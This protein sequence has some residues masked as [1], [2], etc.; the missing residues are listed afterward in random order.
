[1][2][3]PSWVTSGGS[4]GNYVDGIAMSYT[5]VATPS[6]PSNGVYY[7][8]FSGNLPV[9]LGLDA[10]SGTIA[11]TPA[12][13]SEDTQT[14]FVVR[15]TEF[16][17]STIIGTS[18]R[19]FSMSIINNP[20]SWV[21]PI[22]NIG[23]FNQ[24]E[25]LTYTFAA[26]P[27]GTGNTI[28]YSLINGSFPASVGSA[29]TLDTN[30]GELTGT[31]A[32]VS[33]STTSTFTLRATEY[34]GS[35]LV[36][37]S[38][39]I[40]T[41]TI[42]IPQP[43]W[44]TPAG[45]IG[46]FAEGTSVNY[47][48]SG[49]PGSVGDTVRYTLLNGSLPVTQNINSPMI[50]SSNGLLSGIPGEVSANT[51]SDFTIRLEEYSGASRISTNDRTFSMTVI[52][53]DAPTFITTGPW[54]YSDSVWVSIS[55][56]YNNPDPN[57]TISITLVSGQLPPGI[58]LGSQGLLQGYPDIPTSSSITYNFTLRISNGTL[59]SDQ[60][61]SFT[62]NLETGDRN[63]TIYN[64]QPP[65]L[66]MS[67]DQYAA[68]YFTAPS[69]GV[70][71]QGT[72]FIFKIIGHDF[73]NQN[74]TYDIG[75]LDDLGNTAGAVTANA[76][77]GWIYGTLR[78]DIGA[79]SNTYPITA[80]V[81][82]TSD[83]T[84]SSGVFNYTITLLGTVTDDIVWENDDNA[85][86]IIDLGQ[87]YNGQ[88]STKRVRALSSTELD[89]E[90]TLVSGDLPPGLTLNTN[91]EIY[92]R[93]PFESA[94]FKQ[95]QNQ[96][97]VYTF[98]VDA[99]S[100]IY[101][102][103]SSTKTFTLTTVK[104]FT[105]PYDNIYIRAYPDQVQQTIYTDLITNTLLIPNEA[106]YR[107]DYPYFG[108]RMDLVYNHMYGIPSSTTLDYVKSV[109]K[110]HYDRN[111][112]LGE[113]RTARA[114]DENGIVLYEV[115]YSLV[116]DN[117]INNINQSISKQITWPRPINLPDI[118]VRTLYPN[119]LP[120]MR[121]QVA[122]QLGLIN[123]AELLPLWMYS[124]QENGN[125]LGYVQ[126]VVLCYTKSGWA[127]RIAE[128]I[129]DIW[130][131]QLNVIN[132]Q[133]DRFEVDRSI[134]YEYDSNILLWNPN[135]DSANNVWADTLPSG[136]ATDESE[137]TY[138]YFSKNIL[139]EAANQTL[140]ILG[141]PVVLQ[142]N[143]DLGSG[144]TVTIPLKGTVDVVVAWGDGFISNYNTAGNY[145]HT[146]ATPGVYTVTISGTLTGYGS[147]IADNT[148]L[149]ALLSWG[150]TGLTDTSYAFYNATN[151]VLVPANIP[152][153]VT[154]TSYMFAGASSFNSD[155]ST[156]NTRSITNMESMFD[157]ATTFNNNIEAWDVSSVTNMTAMFNAATAFNQNLSNWCVTNISVEPANF[158]TGSALTIGNIPVWGTCPNNQA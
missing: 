125:S 20:P 91:G 119:S 51:T 63:P 47:N 65:Q 61:F 28:K 43:I 25:L 143:T 80:E 1:M 114:T 147:S 112:T 71:Q 117:L 14:T 90:Y 151:L 77:T 21:T 74:L 152:A 66:N 15:A 140:P 134:S 16:N 35:I 17:G 11:G 92:G 38:D 96:Q 97:I 34:S 122:E 32:R 101:P 78:D 93:L 55:L 3:S 75:G 89:L 100:L 118:T 129:N 94:D 87:I 158:S 139:T 40:F 33:R 59:Y 155:I 83:P 76:S 154:N 145:A 156:W 60:P 142:F 137:D 22:G 102:D 115:V 13:V 2:P 104:K 99:N 26:T 149:S 30:T 148:M 68:Y 6:N 50:L 54:T 146:Y 29:F 69:M 108:R 36:G 84:V 85:S 10:D 105:I 103:I 133:L 136:V 72:N 27:A 116:I 135:Y 5:L 109:I 82:R 153:T 124:Q 127:K 81:Y 107:A 132:F 62:V 42:V 9:G 98:T 46:S 70:Y 8:V 144:T 57:T 48:F 23:S 130:Q 58:E 131:Y 19:T 106:I 7:T 37:T 157:E 18:D 121:T 31:P 138:V 64:T 88:V 111:I 67:G 56:L 141:L 24:L 150:D 123:N 52:G 86:E 120:N 44:I 53:P 12:S 39:R 49:N 110:N 126:A 4:I 41:M 113:L 45:S 128:N 95:S 73:D 79:S